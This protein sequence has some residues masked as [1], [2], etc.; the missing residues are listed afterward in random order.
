MP[1]LFFGGAVAYKKIVPELVTPNRYTTDA[2]V[3]GTSYMGFAKASFQP[4]TIKMQYLLGQNLTDLLQIG[5]YGISKI[6]DD[7]KGFVEYTPLRTQTSWLDIHTN[8]KTFQA[9]VFLARSENLGA[10][11]NLVEGSPLTGFGTDIALL[12]RV[13]PRLVFNSGRARFA[14]ETEYT[15]AD[16]GTINISDNSKGIPQN[17]ETVNNL[18]ILLGVYLFL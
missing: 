14:F 13:A 7:D 8:G 15:R 3:A 5:G 18:R 11:E 6:V 12:Y 4:L 9:G 17:T 2:F 16:F 10:T 1:Q